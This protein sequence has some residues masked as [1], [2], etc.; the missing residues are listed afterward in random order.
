MRELIELFTKP[1][2]LEHC[3]LI[4]LLPCIHSMKDR[5]AGHHIPE[6]YPLG[7]LMKVLIEAAH[8]NQKWEV[9]ENEP[10]FYG[11]APN[12]FSFR[13]PQLDHFVDAF[14]D[15]SKHVESSSLSNDVLYVDKCELCIFSVHDVKILPSHLNE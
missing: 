2:N 13:S 1:D 7:E 10:V 9:F 11:G 3:P 12:P 6:S 4:V 8:L 15:S 5:A 14:V